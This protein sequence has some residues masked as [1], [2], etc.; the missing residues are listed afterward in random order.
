MKKML[1]SLPPL[2][3]HI[4]FRRFELRFV[5]DLIPL[6]TKIYVGVVHGFSYVSHASVECCVLR[7]LSGM[8]MISSSFSRTLLSASYEFQWRR[9]SVPKST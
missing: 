2:S 4:C 1:D 9:L 5:T 7:V 3:D 6:R 8:N